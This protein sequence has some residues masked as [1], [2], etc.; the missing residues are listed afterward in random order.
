MEKELV[1][2]FVSTQLTYQSFL[3]EQVTFIKGKGCIHT[4]VGNLAIDYIERVLIAFLGAIAHY[5]VYPFL[6]RAIK[7][8]LLYVIGQNICKFVHIDIAYGVL[9]SF[10]ASHPLLGLL[11]RGGGI[12]STTIVER[13]IRVIMRGSLTTSRL[14]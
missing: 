3:V 13:A 4:I 11:I 2:Q 10:S 7:A 6:G 8:Q 9:R 12:E 14:P 1:Y 5:E